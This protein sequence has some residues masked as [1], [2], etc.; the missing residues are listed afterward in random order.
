MDVGFLVD[1]KSISGY[2]L[3]IIERVKKHEDI[4]TVY[5]LELR[6]S[7]KVDRDLISRVTRSPVA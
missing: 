1:E 5:L 2:E 3:T 7:Q 6:R 4:G